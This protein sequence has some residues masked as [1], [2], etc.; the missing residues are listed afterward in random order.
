LAKGSRAAV[1]AALRVVKDYAELSPSVVWTAWAE[2]FNP[3]LDTMT[4]TSNDSFGP[5]GFSPSD[6]TTHG[7]WQTFQLSSGEIAQLVSQA[8][9]ELK[10]SVDDGAAGSAINLLT[11]EYRSVVLTRPWLRSEVFAARFWRLP[12]TSIPLSDGG[13]PPR[14]RCPAYITGVVFV[15][16]IIEQTASAAGE[17]AHN[18]V[19]IHVLPPIPIRN[20]GSDPHNP[21]VREDLPIVQPLL[22]S[23][24]VNRLNDEGFVS[25]ASTTTPDPSSPPAPNGSASPTAIPDVSVLAFI[26]KPLPKCPNPDLSLSWS[27]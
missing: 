23:E 11:F 15:R 3:D 17:P 22:N 19:P 13:T 5:T 12:A 27:H 2:S 25:L 16:N 20:P 26:C 18:P 9:A 1:E 24:L 6:A 4:D 8:P 21:R 10:T 14:G 7:D